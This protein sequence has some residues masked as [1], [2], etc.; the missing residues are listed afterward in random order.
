LN[1]TPLNG[2]VPTSTNTIT[3]PAANFTGLLTATINVNVSTPSSCVVSQTF[4]LY[5]NRLVSAGTISPSTQTVCPNQI[6]ADIVNVTAATSSHTSA[7]ITYRWEQSTDGG[8]SFETIPGATTSSL[9]FSSP[10]TETTRFRRVAISALFGK[11]CEEATSPLTV[12][13]VSSELCESDTSSNGIG[14]IISSD[15]TLSKDG[16]PYSLTSN[17]LIQ[18]GATLTIE[19]GVI[20][21]VD[22]GKYIKA[23]GQII[24]NGT[25]S[26]RIVFQPKEEGIKWEGIQVRPSSVSNFSIEAPYTYQVEQAFSMSTLRVLDQILITLMSLVSRLKTPEQFMLTIQTYI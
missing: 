3:V 23:E 7:T 4:T 1:G 20:I 26:E 25:S 5:I 10:L 16:S 6:P 2:G 13:T 14:G 11:A 21:N 15:T 24:A 9:S 19:P 17:M 12:V 22:D 8:I 18:E